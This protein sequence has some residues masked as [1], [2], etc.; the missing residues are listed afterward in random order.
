MF[1]SAV[2]LHLEASIVQYKLTIIFIFVLFLSQAKFRSLSPIV[3]VTVSVLTEQ[4]MF[5]IDNNGTIRTKAKLDRETKQNYKINISVSDGSLSDYAIVIVNVTDINDNTP[6][7]TGSYPDVHLSEDNKSG[8][9]VK[10]VL[11]SDLDEGFNS[12]MS[13]SLQGGDGKI[14]ID[15]KTGLITLV[16]ELDR[17]TQASYNLTVIVSDHGQPSRSDKVNFTLTVDDINDNPPIFTNSKYEVKVRENRGTG[18]V[19]L[20]VTATDLDEGENSR[21]E[22]QIVD[23][24]GFFQVNP[25]TGEMSLIQSLDF[26]TAREFSLNIEAK[27]GGSPSLVGKC[28]VHVQ[29]QDVNDNAPEFSQKIYSILVLENLQSGADLYTLNVT[30]KDEVSILKWLN[31]YGVGPYSQSLLKYFLKSIFMD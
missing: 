9:S 1:V 26:E 22:Y 14:D 3:P 18:D 17:E 13:F 25:A 4:D 2:T 29:V 7:F 15:S 23:S 8:T 5:Q 6:T 10:Q 30:D 24:P 11:A 20:N 28:T 12:E 31:T 21:L 27:D 16:K 19:L